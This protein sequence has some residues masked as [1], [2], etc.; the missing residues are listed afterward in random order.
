[1]S[2]GGTF[3]TTG[4]AGSAPAYIRDPIANAAGG[5]VSIGTPNTIEDQ[6]TVDSSAGSFTVTSTGNLPLTG[7]SSFT[8]TGG[9]LAVAGVLSENGGTFTKSAGEPPREIR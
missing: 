1:M 9:T 3:S 8:Q 6:S 2:S 4:V 7:G 5:T